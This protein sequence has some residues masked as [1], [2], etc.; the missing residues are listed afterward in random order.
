MANRPLQGVFRRIRELLAKPT[1]TGVSDAELLERFVAWRDEAAF[2]L[3]VRR[4]EKIVFGVC[5][6]VLHDVHDAEDAFQAAFLVLARKAGAISR[7]ESLAGWLTRVSFRIALRASKKRSPRFAM[8]SL[9]STDASDSGLQTPNTE[10][11][12]GLRGVLDEELDRLPARFRAPVVLCY[13]DGKT[14]E[15]AARQLGWPKGTVASR[16]ARAR[17]RLRNRLVRRGV[18]LSAAALA[19]IQQPVSAAVP[20]ALTDAV[21]HSVH[22]ALAGGAA[23]SISPTVLSLMEG[24]LR[25][26]FWTKVKFT[27]VCLLGVAL[28]G[29]GAGLVAYRVQAGPG[30]PAE[31]LAGGQEPQKSTDA[32]DEIKRLQKTIDSQ[33]A[34]IRKL[35]DT[36]LQLQVELASAKDKIERLQKQVAKAPDDEARE[37]EQ[38]R[39]LIDQV[40]ELRR[41]GR[42]A[43]AQALAHEFARQYLDPEKPGAGKDDEALPSVKRETLRYGGKTFAEWQKELQTEL[44]AEPRAEAMDAMAAFGANGY[45]KEAAETV[46]SL[47]KGYNVV[48]AI[49]DAHDQKV[50][51][52]ANRALQ[53]IGK[54]AEPILVEALKSRDV[55]ARRFA[56]DFLIRF[57]FGPNIVPALLKAT[58]DEDVHVRRSAV[59]AIDPVVLVLRHHIRTEGV[60]A[61]LI[62]ALKDKDQEVRNYAC[63]NLASLELSEKPVAI[64][65]AAAMKDKYSAVRHN[66]AVA[67]GKLSGETKLRVTALA[68]G[69][70]DQDRSVRQQVIG[71]LG[72]MGPEAKEA[73]PALIVAFEK[74]DAG[75]RFLVVQALGNIG[76][77][78]KE[79]LPL[80]LRAINDAQDSTLKG[81]AARAYEKIAGKSHKKPP[82]P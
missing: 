76:P 35:T 26:M 29:G 23:G 56:A 13:F 58:K 14:H 22:L 7:R 67:L 4:Y 44:K 68:E 49:S 1:P 9:D 57:D 50:L 52:A 32:K 64:A 65:L 61:A 2:E 17:E 80:L 79:A 54:P 33:F 63:L 31:V 19:T 28:L 48:E 46:V 77:D 8:Q 11:S 40:R 78:A 5:L 30:E 66:A 16:L 37:L 27:T 82:A 59:S 51:N 47:M 3:L 45:A 24:A 20:Q 36:A 12:T 74:V 72:T 75:D 21:L 70:K 38:I 71:S 69:L 41:Q 6:R 55:N 10:L 39:A 62:D 34:T 25:T 60:L 15:E 73:V 53:K 81:Y 43:E 42:L 18:T